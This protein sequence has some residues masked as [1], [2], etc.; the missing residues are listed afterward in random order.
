MSTPVSTSD[1]TA[2]QISPSDSPP[3]DG[4][5]RRGAP[6]PWVSMTLACALLGASGGVRAWQDYRFATVENRSE[7]CPFPLKDLPKTLGDEWTLQEGGEKVLDPEVAQVAGCRDSLIRTYRN[8]TTGVN[9][10]AL[11][12]FGPSKA[13]VG[14]TPEVCYPA[15]GYRMYRDPTLR[16]VALR[17]DAHGPLPV[18]E[19]RTGVYA[20]EREHR[21]WR[22]EVYYAFRH[23]D[24]WSPDAARHYKD[25]RHHPSMFK[26]QVQRPVSETERNEGN[27]PTEQFL[28]LLI[29]QIESR[30]AQ[31]RDG[32][33]RE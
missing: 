27:N 26:V 7:S 5:R 11:I 14:H 4:S 12:L 13:V 32:G 23:G 21:H 17:P 6:S 30:I 16:S 15:A 9:V 33:R 18:A 24:R 31:P 8:A 22:D 25:F 28:A 19:F 3:A 20:R 29:P 10:T 2:T 1:P